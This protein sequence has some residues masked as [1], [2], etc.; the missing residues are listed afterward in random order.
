MAG[1]MSKREIK[2][3]EIKETIHCLRTSLVKKRMLCGADAH[4][5]NAV[6]K[7]TTYSINV[8]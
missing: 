5:F 7:K 1:I 6:M 3:L 4:F 8:D 2:I